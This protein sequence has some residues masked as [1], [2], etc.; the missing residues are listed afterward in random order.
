[1]NLGGS[2]PGWPAVGCPVER[3]VMRS[4][5]VGTA[6]MKRGGSS[7][8]SLRAWLKGGTVVE[9]ALRQTSRAAVWAYTKRL[10]SEDLLM[11]WRRAA[12]GGGGAQRP[13]LNDLR[14][15]AVTHNVEL[16]GA[17]RRT[18]MPARSIMD[19]C[20]ARAWTAAVARPVER[21]VRPQC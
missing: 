3:N 6:A 20:A 8:P 1:M 4:P 11:R 12:P 2:R 18:A 13:N 16:T 19:L 17:R 9:E 21:H 7:K 14:A 10:P 15:A 5:Q